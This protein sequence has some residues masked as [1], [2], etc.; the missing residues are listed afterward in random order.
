MINLCGRSF[1]FLSFNSLEIL[2]LFSGFKEKI[3]AL[4]LLFIS[5]NMDIV[6]IFNMNILVFI[7]PKLFFQFSS[8]NTRFDIF[9][10]VSI[11]SQRTSQAIET[12]TTIASFI[13]LMNASI[14]DQK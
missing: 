5:Q 6:L 11:S 10:Y 4:N 13:I 1:V 2:L 12:T 9:S 14:L 7:L 8:Q 3:I